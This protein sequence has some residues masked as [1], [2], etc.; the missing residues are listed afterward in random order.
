MYQEMAFVQWHMPN[1][2]PCGFSTNQVTCYK[3]SVNGGQY[4]CVSRMLSPPTWAVGLPAHGTHWSPLFQQRSVM[5]ANGDRYLNLKMK[6]YIQC[7]LG[8]FGKMVGGVEFW[9]V[10]WLKHGNEFWWRV[11]TKQKSIVDGRQPTKEIFS[12]DL[13]AIV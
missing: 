12:A 6:M 9:N 13:T 8:L 11:T 10:E 2:P 7:V 4:T 5:Y 1:M 3:T